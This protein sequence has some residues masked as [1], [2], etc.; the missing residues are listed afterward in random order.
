MRPLKLV[1]QAF[2]P[3]PGREEV[4]FRE[5]VA[6]GLF[7]IY[8]PT[9]S[10]KSSIFSAMTFALFGESAKD[11]Q[12]I[13]T[14]RSDHAPAG[15]LTEVEFLFELAGRT[16]YVRRCPDQL[17][18]KVRGTGDTEEKH[19]AWLFDVTGIAVDEICRDNC[20]RVIAERKVSDVDRAVRE[21]LGYGATQFRQIVLLPQGRFE[22]FLAAGSSDRMTILRDLFDVSLYRSLTERFVEGARAA[23]TEVQQGRAVCA[24]RLS[25]QGFESAEAL[26]D[27][28]AVATS[29]AALCEDR[30]A[31]AEAEE[32]RVSDVYARAEALEARF[33]EA[34]TAE[35]ELADLE[36]RKEEIEKLRARVA[37]LRLAEAL[38]DF[39]RE[40]EEAQAEVERAASGRK[41]TVA[42]AREAEDTLGTAKLALEQELAREAETQRLQIEQNSVERYRDILSRASQLRTD[43]RNADEAWRS[44]KV[45]LK[46]AVER[47]ETCET[48]RRGA[49]ERLAT[50]RATEAQRAVLVAEL[51]RASSAVSA[52][53][54]YEA[55]VRSANQSEEML[56]SAEQSLETARGE[57]ETAERHYRACSSKLAAAQA[58]R[59]AELLEPGEP[60]PVCGSHDHPTPAAGAVPAAGLEE[61]AILAEAAWA[62]ARKRETADQIAFASAKSS[63]EERRA[64]LAGLEPP[65]VPLAQLETNTAVL[66][67]KL[68]A[69]GDPVD[70]QELDQLAEELDV[71]LAESGEELE[72]A[73]AAEQEAGRKCA[74]AAQALALALEGVPEAFRA[75]DALDVEATRLAEEIDTR[76]KALSTAR[77]K[78]SAAQS[79]LAAAQTAV[80]GAEAR[81]LELRARAT[82]MADQ[83]NDRLVANGLSEAE[84]RE[85][86]MALTDMDGLAERCDEFDR[87]LSAAKGRLEQVRAAIE[88]SERP[89][90]DALATQKADSGA[91]AHAARRDAIEANA[92]KSALEA[93]ASELRETLDRLDA[94]EAESGPLRALAAAFKG[95]N[96]LR[97]PLETY[98]IGALFDHVLRSANLR[99]NPMTQGR[100]RLERDTE[101][102]GG[103]AKRGLDVRVHD[104]HTGR[105][106]EIC[107]LSGGETFIAALSLA[108]G[109]SD[110]VETSHGKIRLDTIFIDEG[111]GSLDAEEDSGTLDQVLQVL[112]N[113]V[114]RHRPVGLIS[115]VPQVQQAIPN[116]F[117]IRKE[118]CGSF[119]EARSA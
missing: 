70:P 15:L 107:T 11:E 67:M 109:L 44:A 5:A 58:Q 33:V 19:C 87:N 72:A 69:L 113:V 78:A 61:A 35:K 12:R 94:I 3:Y 4:D 93:L 31:E 85:L 102:V 75:P 83:L 40:V 76:T 96:A 99:F 97:T 106:R 118:P 90:L 92:R 86:K 115:H 30:A 29:E 16:Y 119:V 1:L 79:A 100:Y 80:V 14:L 37:K 6:A 54:G 81:L 22:R 50:D 51:E 21:L 28:I 24:L 17:R 34:A 104:A 101:T 20:G 68:E 110:I 2:G 88:A 32:R 49:L 95:E 74:L 10:G 36:G 65:A 38:V 46:T 91:L 48:Y 18:P 103:R 47:Y 116:G 43:A 39:D 57:T 23:E 114:G 7:G 25:Q 26:R 62:Q 60:C 73:R 59:L 55:A 45:E 98:A 42:A 56:S 52:A 82:R 108:L 105:T 13:S 71:E 77:E 27:G 117:T 63:Y 89:D 41:V 9:G 66:R 112:Q 8:G 111:F 64:T 84:Y 53:R